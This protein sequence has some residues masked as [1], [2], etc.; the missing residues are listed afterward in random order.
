[1]NVAMPR[2]RTTAALLLAC[3]LPVSSGG[4]A[5]SPAAA[6][7]QVGKI[8][9]AVATE[10]LEGLGGEDIKTLA[11][12]VDIQPGGALEPI[13]ADAGF[14]HYEDLPAGPYLVRL[15]RLPTHCRARG[16]SQRRVTVS[17]GST[18]RA[19]FAVKCGLRGPRS[20]HAS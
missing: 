18:A 9:V 14:L 17:P 4:C 5:K 11:F 10:G 15:I 3:I 8:R 13:P 16:P 2:S 7:P 12:T 19:S 20:R 1:M 6:G